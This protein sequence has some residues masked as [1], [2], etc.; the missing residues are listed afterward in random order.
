MYNVCLCFYVFHLAADSND[1]VEPIDIWEEEDETDPE[2]CSSL[3]FENLYVI[4]HSI[5]IS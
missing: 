4:F 2:V 3:S 5:C 1:E